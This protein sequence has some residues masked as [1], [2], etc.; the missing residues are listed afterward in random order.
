[1][2][3]IFK[4]YINYLNYWLLLNNKHYHLMYFV[5]S[6]VIVYGIDEGGSCRIPYV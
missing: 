4:F 5:T 6:L 2:Y 1:M 3:F